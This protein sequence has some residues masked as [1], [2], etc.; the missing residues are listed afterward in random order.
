MENEVKNDITYHK[1]GDYYIPNIVLTGS[2]KD[3]NLRKYGRMRA[4]Y[5]KL[6]KPIEYT[7]LLMDNELQEHLLEIDKTAN[8]RLKL[9]INNLAEKENI[10]EELKANNQMEWVRCMNNISNRAEEII[11]KELIYV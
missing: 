5:L 6:H 10:T 11:L 1:V 7:N 8:E 4:R 2:E 3:I 9:I